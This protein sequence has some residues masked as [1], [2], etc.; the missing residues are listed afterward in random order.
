MPITVTSCD[1]TMNM[2]TTMTM[3]SSSSIQHRCIESSQIEIRGSLSP[4][5]ML[6]RANSP[7]PACKIA[8]LG[9]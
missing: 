7:F 9:S 3:S 4:H 5:T 1:M 8:G 6:L 2:A